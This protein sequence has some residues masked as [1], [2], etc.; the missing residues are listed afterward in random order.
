MTSKVITTKAAIAIHGSISNP[1]WI[2]ISGRVPV[3]SILPREPVTRGTF[4]V[5]SPKGFYVIASADGVP[6]DV[7][8]RVSPARDA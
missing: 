7:R 6:S 3:N 2:P 8:L 4:Y 5:L 1:I